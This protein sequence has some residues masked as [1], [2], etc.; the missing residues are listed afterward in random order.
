M[1]AY[2]ENALVGFGK[3][4]ASNWYMMYNDGYI[5]GAKSWSDWYLKNCTNKG[6]FYEYLVL[7]KRRM[8]LCNETHHIRNPNYD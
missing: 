2:D 3:Y 4:K 1:K 5:S 6:K 7:L 8:E